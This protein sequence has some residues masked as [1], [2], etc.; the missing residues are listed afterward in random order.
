MLNLKSIKE[1]LAIVILSYAD[2]ESLEIALAVH[3]KFFPHL[4]C[5]GGGQRVKLFILQNGYGTYDCERTLNV[6]LRYKDLYPEDIEVIT[7]I[8]PGP[9]YHSIRSL[10]ESET[11]K[12]IKYIIKLDDDVFPLS[13]NWLDDLCSCYIESFNKY[14]NNLA[15]VTGLVNNNPYGFKKTLEIMDLKDLYFSKYARVHLSGFASEPSTPVTITP[16]DTISTNAGGTIWRYA[17]IARFIHQQTTLKP[18]KFIDATK[19]LGSER[20]NE[21]ERYSINCMLFEKE[22]WTAFNPNNIPDDEASCHHYCRD[23]HM[24][25]VAALN[26]PLVHLFFYVQRFENKDLIESIR[27]L[28]T[29]WLN[30]PFKIA[31]CEDK[32]RENE[33]R[34]RY[35]EKRIHS[36]NSHLLL[37]KLK[38]IEKKI[39]YFFKTK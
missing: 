30:L 22:F 29:N 21:N 19:N 12:D 39:K 31:L 33:E 5:S 18:Q 4:T 8:S 34:L 9:A 20:I 16:K 1:Q 10:L 3:S 35:L 7:N 6:A 2:Y 26:V 37:Q 13:P 15:Y 14:K 28:Y 11:F 27:N 36:I 23:N 25:I 24:A 38:L 32:E 17:Y